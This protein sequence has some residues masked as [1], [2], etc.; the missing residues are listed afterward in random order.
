MSTKTNFLVNATEFLKG[1]KC[2]AECQVDF[3]LTAA[4]LGDVLQLI[5]LPQGA[6]VDNAKAYIVTAAG[7]TATMSLGDGTTPNGWDASVNLNATAGT[8]T[9]TLEATDT[10]GVGKLYTATDTIDAVITAGTSL[11]AGKF[12]VYVEYS[13]SELNDAAS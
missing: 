1:Q 5:T 8:M 6:V 10:Y 7:K 12:N 9:R 3:S 2:V 13:V 11:T 4:S